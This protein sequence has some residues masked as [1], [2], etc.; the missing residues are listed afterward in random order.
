[1]TWILLR[2]GWGNIGAIIALALLPLVS[3]AVDGSSPYDSRLPQAAADI[4][5][6]A[7]NDA[8]TGGDAERPVSPA[9]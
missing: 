8:L 6:V 3:L 5:R 2:L 7:D 1:M 4:E 9:G